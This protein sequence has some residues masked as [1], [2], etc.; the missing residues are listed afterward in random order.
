MDERHG[1]LIGC[2][3]DFA[4]IRGEIRRLSNGHQNQATAL[5]KLT[6]VVERD[7]ETRRHEHDETVRAISTYQSQ[8]LDMATGLSERTALT[9]ASARSAHHRLDAQHK[10]IWAILILAGTAMATA[11]AAAIMKFLMGG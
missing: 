3:R 8:V 10:I 6:D 5:T 9:E 11:I 1:R 4:E 7:V 2:E